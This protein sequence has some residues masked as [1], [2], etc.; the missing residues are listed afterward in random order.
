MIILRT[1]SQHKQIPAGTIE[2]MNTRR[3]HS[4]KR[5]RIRTS[6]SG[7]PDAGTLRNV[8][9]LSLALQSSFKTTQIE[10][11]LSPKLKKLF[12]LD[13]EPYTMVERPGFVF[14]NVY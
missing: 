8:G 11:E 1:I 7:E 3:T 6:P 14:S 10:I 13:I 5:Q 4:G 12:A 9:M 2:G